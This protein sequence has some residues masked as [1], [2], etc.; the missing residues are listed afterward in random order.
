MDEAVERDETIKGISDHITENK[1]NI[2]AMFWEFDKDGGG[3]I[4]RHE[5]AKGLDIP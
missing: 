1:L 3:E 5:L 2:S 4:E